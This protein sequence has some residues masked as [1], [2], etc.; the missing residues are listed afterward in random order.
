MD[1]IITNALM[2][3]GA[4]F[5]TAAIT[6]A[7]GPGQALD[8]MMT[9]V[10]FEK[11]HEV[12]EKKRAK[13][14]Q[15]IKD[16]K[17]SIATEIS[18]IPEENIQEPPLSIVGP[19]LEASK[20]YIEEED[21]RDMFAKLIAG[22]MD[23]SKSSLSHPSFVEIIKQMSPQDAK[24]IK[25]ISKNGI[26]F[27]NISCSTPLPEFPKYPEHEEIKSE[28]RRL[29]Q[30]PKLPE[31]PDFESGSHFLIQENFFIS[32]EFP[33]YLSNSVSI[34]SLSRLGLLRLVDLEAKDKT[35]Y[36]DLIKKFEHFTQSD[37]MENERLKLESMSGD[38]L[39]YR[40]EKK[41][42]L[43]SPLGMAFAVVC[44]D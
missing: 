13:R 1:P 26:A 39:E 18:K 15:N 31:F 24:L 8:D 21:L 23:A 5:T 4:G 19:A 29:N 17:N 41:S 14:D 35:V 2:T 11:L 38:K 16:Y 34:S 44:L 32:D 40:L 28:I 10:G 36:N 37:F 22:S 7:K 6:K 25:Q 33:D 42:L 30:I 27:G 12:A 9:L 20:F 43:L 3:F